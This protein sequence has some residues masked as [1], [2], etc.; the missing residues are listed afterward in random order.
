MMRCRE[1]LINGVCLRL[2]EYY[3]NVF[4]KVECVQGQI[5]HDEEDI[6]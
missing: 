2:N 4:D 5:S 6:L 1:Y 3:I